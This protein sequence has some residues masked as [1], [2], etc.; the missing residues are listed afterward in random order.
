MST[1]ARCKGCGIELQH[2]DE[3]APGYAKDLESTYCKACYRLLHYGEGG[4]HLHPEDLP[5]LKANGLVLMVASVLHLDLLFSYPIYRYQPDARFVYIINQVDLLPDSTNLDLFLKNLVTKAER[6]HIPF[7]QIILMSAKNPKDLENL[8]AYLDEQPEKDIHLIGVQN[9]GKTTIFKALTDDDRALALKKAGLTQRVLTGVMKSHVIYDM[10]G[11]YQTGYLH[12]FMEY[13]DYRKLIPEK[14]IRPRIYALDSGQSIRIE[15]LFIVTNLS[16]RRS[17]V[18]YLSERVR[19][20][21]VNTRK[22]ADSI[23]RTWSKKTFHRLGGKHQITFSDMGM[24]HVEGPFK[25]S[26]HYVTEAH[27]NVTEA[28]FK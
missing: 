23:D 22:I 20:D 13:A 4:I 25:M 14:T 15:D 12:Q 9:S 6:M 21:R 1:I 5:K 2:T 8:R 11:L 10:P 3:H 27:V 7:E 18:F 28:L 19:L 17:V 26:L 16:V 24:M